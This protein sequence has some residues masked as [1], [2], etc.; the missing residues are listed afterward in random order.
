[1]NAALPAYVIRANKLAENRDARRS[2]FRS[3]GMSDQ[4]V[5]DELNFIASNLSDGWIKGRITDICADMDDTLEPE[6]WKGFV[7]PSALDKGIEQ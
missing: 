6:M 3:G 7:A 4:E 1:M 5:F 2:I